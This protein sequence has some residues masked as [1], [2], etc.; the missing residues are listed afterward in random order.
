MYQE[1]A[2]SSDGPHGGNFVKK[3]PRTRGAPLIGVFSLAHGEGMEMLSWMKGIAS[4]ARIGGSRCLLL[5][6]IL[7]AMM[8]CCSS[9]EILFTPED[10]VEVLVNKCSMIRQ[11]LI[12]DLIS[13]DFEAGQDYAEKY[14]LLLLGGGKDEGKRKELADGI[15]TLESA[16]FLSVLYRDGKGKFEQAFH[17]SVI[18]EIRIDKVKFI[19]DDKWYGVGDLIKGA[20]IAQISTGGVGI[21]WWYSRMQFIFFLPDTVIVPDPKTAI[22]I[23]EAVCRPIYGD[24]AVDKERPYHATLADGVW[25]VTGTMPPNVEGG[26]AIVNISQKDGKIISVIHGK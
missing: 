26:V 15:S 8:S 22:A 14:R 9:S 23:A 11:V 25:T 16:L 10:T 3:N 18:E 13:G 21:Q 19:G 17:D 24:V 20:K 4:K 5:V 2:S 1:I 7:L 12:E 6:F